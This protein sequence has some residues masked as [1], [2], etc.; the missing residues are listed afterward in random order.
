MSL[1]P[2]KLD[3]GYARIGEYAV[4]IDRASGAQSTGDITIGVRPESW[5]I[6]GERENGLP[7]RISAIEELGAD[8]FIYGT[9]DVE[10]DT[11]TIAV[12]MGGRQHAHKGQTIF[13]STESS[14]VHVFD[15][16]TGLRL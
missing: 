14:K 4:A 5:R 13:L 12:H 10:G 8:A 11:I 3:D 15:T 1:I 9:C 6:V 7:I 2:A 16:T